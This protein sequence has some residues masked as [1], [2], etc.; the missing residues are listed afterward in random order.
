MDVDDQESG[1]ISEDSSET[2]AHTDFS[3]KGGRSLPFRDCGIVSVDCGP[4]IFF[5][6]SALFYD[7]RVSHFL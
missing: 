4:L 3:E 7:G 1:E 6:G 2:L 5:S